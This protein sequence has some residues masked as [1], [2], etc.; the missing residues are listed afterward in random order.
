MGTSKETVK[1]QGKKK[2]GNNLIKTNDDMLNQ[3]DDC[4]KSKR[5]DLLNEG[6]SA[7]KENERKIELLENVRNMYIVTKDLLE[8]Y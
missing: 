1:G 8:S 2:D 7:R 3:I 5:E 4:L 6:A